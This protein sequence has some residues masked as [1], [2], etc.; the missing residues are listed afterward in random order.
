VVAVSEDSIR[1]EGHREALDPLVMPLAEMRALRTGRALGATDVADLDIVLAQDFRR[2][3]HHAASR[4]RWSL[5]AIFS[6][7]CG[8]MP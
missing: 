6:T 3:A 8:S 2:S 5:M 7:W 4:F 1:G